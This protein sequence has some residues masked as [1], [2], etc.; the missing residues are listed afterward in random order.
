MITK[1]KLDSRK[2][3]LFAIAGSGGWTVLQCAAGRHSDPAVLELLSREHP[4]ALQTTD[5]YGRTPQQLATNYNRPAPITSLLTSATNA[6]AAL[7]SFRTRLLLHLL[8]FSPFTPVTGSSKDAS[9]FS[10]RKYA[11]VSRP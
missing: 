3:T 9:P 2:R 8:A 4:L 1:A 11:A 7:R 6:L 5:N 10:G